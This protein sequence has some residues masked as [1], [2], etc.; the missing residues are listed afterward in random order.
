MNL[1]EP[2]TGIIKTMPM[3]F[4]QEYPGSQ[5][6][7]ERDLESLN[8]T[9]YRYFIFNIAGRPKYEVLYFYL[10]YNGKIRYRA[11]IL[12]YK[13]YT[14]GKVLLGDGRTLYGKLFIHVSAPII[15]CTE[16][17]LMKGFQGFRYTNTLF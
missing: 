9:D 2:P 4:F 15:K 8:N 10:L 17:I 16:D 14:D 13:K 11:N 6:T 3:K 1:A 12:E 5:D 7:F